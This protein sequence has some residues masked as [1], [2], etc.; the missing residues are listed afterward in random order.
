VV[1]FWRSGSGNMPVDAIR[2]AEDEGWDGQTF[3]DSLS[4][5][6]NVF[7]LM[8]AAAV[9]TDRLMLAT[10]VTNPLTRHIALVASG[11]AGVQALSN[12]RSVLGIGRGGLAPVPIAEFKRALLDLRALLGGSTI[13]APLFTSP[14]GLQWM[15][16][17]LPK[18]PLDVAASGPKVITMAAPIAERLTFSLG[19]I[20]E[21]IAWAIAVARGARARAGISDAGMSYGVQVPVICHPDRATALQ[22]AESMVPALARFQLI[23]GQWP[24]TMS[25]DDERNFETL[26]QQFANVL[27]RGSSVAE[28]RAK[29]SITPGFVGR[30]AIVGPPEVCIGR[31]LE[32]VT[33]GIERF[34]IVGPGHYPEAESSGQSL[35]SSEVMPAVRAAVGG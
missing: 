6:P 27:G 3:Q 4:L 11:A 13:E 16:D 29:S 2:A 26:N 24:G 10:G 21:R 28:R 20:P 1:E 25:E 7:A 18:V 33:I 23:H 12:G 30:F 15:P 19:A 17:H 35:F 9:A 14:T 8:G 22:I 32:L 5:C 34:V 31:L